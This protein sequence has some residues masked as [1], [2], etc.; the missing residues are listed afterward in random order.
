M[1]VLIDSS[2]FIFLAAS[3]Q[4]AGNLVLVFCGFVGTLAGYKKNARWLF[5][6]FLSYLHFPQF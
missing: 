3:V 2:A 1:T 4:S 5:L 6:W